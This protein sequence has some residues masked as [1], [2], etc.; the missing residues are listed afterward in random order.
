M[1]QQE[2]DLE[3]VSCSIHADRQAVALCASC[4]RPACLAC[5]VPFRGEVLC[6][7]CAARALGEELP[8]EGP[9]PVRASRPDPVAGALVLGALLL[10]IPPWHRFGPLDHP[11]AALRPTPEP[12]PMITAL[13]LL[14]ALVVAVAPRP[15]RLRSARA[16][17]LALVLLLV[18]AG[19][20]VAWSVMGSRNFIEHSPVPYVLLAL[21]AAA[22][23]LGLVRTLRMPTRVQDVAG[24]AP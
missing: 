12:W 1:A 21:V 24:R 10:T 13:L 4:G 17:G 2:V 11:L 16:Q 15:L 5:S 20:A 22:V 18:P 19:A 6:T 8:E 3:R 14:G 7:A 9:T 23:T